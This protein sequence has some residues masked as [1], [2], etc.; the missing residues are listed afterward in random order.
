MRGEENMVRVLLDA[1]AD[2]DIETPPNCPNFPQANNETQHWTA[3]TFA[4]LMGHAKIV[5]V[6]IDKNINPYRMTS[7]LPM[8]ELNDDV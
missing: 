2:S 8:K 5:K 3:L 1:G 6:R 4:A 7:Q